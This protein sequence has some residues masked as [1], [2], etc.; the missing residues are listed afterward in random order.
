MLTLL[1]E[2]ATVDPLLNAGPLSVTVHVA[3]AG[4]FTLDGVHEIALNV[5]GTGWMML[6]EPEAPDAGIGIPFASVITTPAI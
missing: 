4:A 2:R 3:D 6:I 5:G 1:L